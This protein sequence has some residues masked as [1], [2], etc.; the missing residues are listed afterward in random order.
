MESPAATKFEFKDFIKVFSLSILL[1]I[2]FSGLLSYFPQSA[3][4]IESLPPTVS[5]LVQYLI[6]FLVL[7]FPLWLFVFGKYAATLS[8]F[9]FHKV[10]LWT[11]IKT[12]LSSYV[13]YIAIS[14]VIA[15]FLYSINLSLPGYEAQESYI[16]LFGNN[17][18]GFIIAFL[19]IAII[20]P[21][22][23]EFFFRGFIYRVFTKTWPV[24]IGSLMTAV[25]FALIHFQLAS[26][27]PLLLL[28]LILNYTYHKTGSVWTAVA[29]HSLNNSIAF[30]L[31]IYLYFHPELIQNFI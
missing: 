7:F 1:F 25:L 27:F 18:L 9:G 10:R 23:E 12:I 24:W 16:P 13:F 21:F 11:L 30:G 3:D 20:A 22:L 29:F 14:I 8:D 31:D 19:F 17:I 26:F 2:F 5:F 15:T 6:Q 28:G 4:F